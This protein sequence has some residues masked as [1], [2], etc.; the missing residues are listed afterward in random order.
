[1]VVG[2]GKGIAFGGALAIVAV[3]ILASVVLYLPPGINQTTNNLSDGVTASTAC[4]ITGR[5][6][7]IL[8]V[9]NSS[10]GKPIASV[11]VSIS[12][13]VIFTVVHSAKAQRTYQLG[14]QTVVGLSLFNPKRALTTF[15]PIISELIVCSLR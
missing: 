2:Y 15:K 3:S 1:V 4:L 12:H 9:L 6:V 8:R 11:P 7:L 10:S 13:L 14:V 5:G